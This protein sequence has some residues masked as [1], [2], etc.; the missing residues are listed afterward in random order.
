MDPQ[1][2][3]R[4]LVDL[5]NRYSYEYYVNDNPSVSDTEYDRLMRELEEL[6]TAYPEY[7]LADSPT[8]RVG[9][10]GVTKLPKVTFAEPMLSL[11]NAFSHEELRAFDN[12][13]K[14]EGIIP[15]YVCE[16]KIDGIASSA[17]YENGVFTLGATRGDGYTGENITAN[18]KT[19]DRK[20]VV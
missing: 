5:L 15:A 14:R 1:K 19:I 13:I 11:A 16:L 4:E 3:I 2:R 7:V 8:R 20:S 6:E 18:M 17:R 10:L 9:A 12:R